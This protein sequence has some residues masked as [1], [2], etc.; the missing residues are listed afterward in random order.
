MKYT[1]KVLH[2]C[3]RNCKYDNLS[4]NFIYSK[5]KDKFYW[6]YCALSLTEKKTLIKA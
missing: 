4:D 5:T 6:I 3:N 2:G 1:Q